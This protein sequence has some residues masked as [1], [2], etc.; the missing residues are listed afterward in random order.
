M[1][2]ARRARVPGLDRLAHRARHRAP[3]PRRARSRWP[4]AR[5]R[6]RAP[7]RARRRRRC[8]R[9]ASRITG[10]PACSTMIAQVVRVADPRARADRRAERHHRGAADVL[11]PAREDRVVVRVREDDE[12]VGDELLGGGA[13]SSTASGKSV[14]SS[15]ITSSL[16]QSVSSASRASGRC[17]PR[18]APC[19]SRP[20]SGAGRGRAARGR[21]APS[22]WRRVDAA[23]R[24]RRDLGARRLE[25]LLH[26]RRAS[27]SRRC[28]RSG[29]T[30]TSRRRARSSP[31]RVIRPGIACRTSTRWPSRERA[32]RPRRCAARPR[33][34]PRPRRRGAPA[35]RRRPRR[36]RR[37]WRRARPRSARAVQ[38]DPHATASVRHELGDTC[39]RGA[40]R[41]GCRCGSGRWRATRPVER[42]RPDHAARCRACRAQAGARL[43]ELQ[44]GEPGK[45]R[46]RPRAAARGRRRR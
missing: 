41:A 32:S 6:S 34:R 40:A 13:A 29:A 18:R 2:P 38:L 30:P 8:R 19:S 4:A 44:L 7:S 16:T 15:P 33:R 46:G 26:R 24:D 36:R 10:T 27:G 45:Q 42:A 12:A 14:R 3:G 43:D 28:R 22:P 17:G 35:R 31:S 21:R 23:Q 9:P 39:R 25:R 37:P 11:E 1:R 5:R 20:C